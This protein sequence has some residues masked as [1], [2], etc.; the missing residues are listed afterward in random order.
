MRSQDLSESNYF[1]V[2]PKRIEETR[3]QPYYNRQMQTITKRRKL[4]L[5]KILLDN[6]NPIKIIWVDVKSR[7]Q[8]KE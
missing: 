8:R 3:V 2:P 5:I 6:K 4:D 1:V 7:K